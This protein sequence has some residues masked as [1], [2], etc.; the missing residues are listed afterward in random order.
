MFHSLIQKMASMMK[1]VYGKVGGTTW[2]KSKKILLKEFN[3]S[4][5]ADFIER[6]KQFTSNNMLLTVILTHE[7]L[8]YQSTMK[9]G[10]FQSCHSNSLL[11]YLQLD[12]DFK[13]TISV[14]LDEK[15]VI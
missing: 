4:A 2:F 15:I 11:I 1:W 13:F 6:S 14:V 12:Q 8:L 7:Q 5:Q 3:L 10:H 9:S